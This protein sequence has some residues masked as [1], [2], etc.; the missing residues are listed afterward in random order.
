[1][2]IN[3]KHDSLSEARAYHKLS[4]E[5]N[6]K[7]N[8]GSVETNQLVGHPPVELSSLIFHFINTDD[9]SVT[10]QVKGKRKREIGLVLLCK[11]FACV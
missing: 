10:V 4:V 5:I 6:Q 8:N 9:S 3:P 1:M 11:H 7:I 2:R